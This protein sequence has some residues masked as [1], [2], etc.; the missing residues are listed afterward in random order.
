ME[1]LIDVQYAQTK[2]STNT[3]EMGMR[4]MQALAYEARDSNYILLKA[5]PASGKSRA[6][7]FLALY[8]LDKTSAKKAIIAVPEQSIGASFKSTKLSE[9]GFFSDWVV[10]EKYNLC[11]GSGSKSKV[12]T[13]KEFLKDKDADVLV[14]THATF[15]EAFKGLENDAFNDTVLGIDEFHH[16]TQGAGNVIGETL[17]VI[18][19]KT[20]AQIIAM[21]GS[22]FRGD[23]MAILKPEHENRF[24]SIT[25]NYY[26]QLNGYEY[27]KSL[28]IGYHFYQGK[29]IEGLKE[30][31]D[32]SKKTIIHIPSVNSR[33][34]YSD[35]ITEVDNI[36]DL[37]GDKVVQDNDTGLLHVERK[38][39]SIIIVADLVN[40]KGDTRLKV[41]RFLAD[42]DH[43][44]DVDIVIALGMAKEGFD[45]SFCEHALTIGYR[46]SLTEIVQIIGRCTRDSKNKTHAQFTNLVAEPDAT[47]DDVAAA[48]NDMLKAITCSLLMEQ[49]LA[50]QF[51]FKMRQTDE[52]PTMTGNTITIKGITEPPT[53]KA[54]DIIENKLTELKEKLIANTQIM[55]ATISGE[56]PQTI[57]QQLIP[58]VIQETFPDLNLEEIKSVRDAVVLDALFAGNEISVETDKDGADQRFLNLPKTLL[59]IDKLDI[60]MVLKV[61]PFQ[62]AY[63][64]ISKS[65]TAEMF[66]EVQGYIQS[67]K[68]NITEEEVNAN[69]HLVEEFMEKEGKQPDHQSDNPYEKRLGLIAIKAIAYYQKAMAENA[70]EKEV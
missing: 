53:P 34:A 11:L 18:M 22:Y 39:G 17:D 29:Y 28:G 46:G 69:F 26:Q 68:A 70:K 15:R 32:V 36:I 25:Y 64:V 31:L 16:V 12:N 1:N 67:V 63:E 59:H 7:M 65:L 44:D 48:V 54:K 20:S 6:L 66:K 3:N 42:V 8:K 13:F 2:T 4:E 9:F 57:N 21:T 43:V 49:I 35:K 37:I 27:L 24:H 38:D 47:S 58:K 33:E 45:W 55:K 62:K 56:D 51:K 19:D 41:K 10:D 5:P 30:I 60:D 61:N 40:D 50:P 52:D 23:A 14:C